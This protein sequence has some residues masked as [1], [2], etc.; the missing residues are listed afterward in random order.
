MVPSKTHP[1]WA[2][3]LQGRID[4]KFSNAAASMMLFRL[5]CDIKKDESPVALA[6]AVDMMHAFATKY[7]R[8]LDPDIKAIF[9]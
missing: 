6:K 3:L 7:E 1:K 9:N 5:K 8:M 4:Y 2:A